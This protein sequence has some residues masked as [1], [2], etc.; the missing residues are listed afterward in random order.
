MVCFQFLLRSRKDGIR[1]EG[2]SKV[3]PLMVVQTDGYSHSYTKRLPSDRQVPGARWNL[4]SSTA[5]GRNKSIYLRALAGGS[6]Q[7][8]I[9]IA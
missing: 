3:L 6:N 4:V 9:R 8:P 1:C 5:M 2:S 7:T